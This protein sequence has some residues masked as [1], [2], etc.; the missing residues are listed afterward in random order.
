MKEKIALF[1]AGKRLKRG[2][3]S[4]DYTYDIVCIYD[5][6][7][8]KH[9][10]NYIFTTHDGNEKSVEIRNFENDEIIADVT[11]VITPIKWEGIYN[12]LREKGVK[13]IRLMCNYFERNRGYKNELAE[14]VWRDIIKLKMDKAKCE[15]E[16]MLC[17]DIWDNH[18]V[19]PFLVEDLE[20]LVTI[21][22]ND[23]ILDYGCGCGSLVLNMRTSGF[24]NVL[25]V[26]VDRIKYDYCQ[27]KIE[28]MQ[29]PREWMSCISMYDGEN[30]P[31]DSGSFDIV[32]SDMVM[33]HVKSI[34]GSL[35]E[36]LSFKNWWIYL[37]TYSKLQF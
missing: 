2:I 9:D 34:K 31:Y 19:K 12:Q 26:E 33:E 4:L 35:M 3:A 16:E 17:W 25:G 7:V 37:Y 10:T 23:C 22:K 36:M 8:E 15:E 24:S 21:D 18:Y 27:A 13:K 14:Y 20:E 5:N 6:S 30:L 29:Y 32:V 1:G 28:E 11:Y